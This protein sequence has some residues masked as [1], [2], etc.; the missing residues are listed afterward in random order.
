ML[1]NGLL[2]W[3]PDEVVK[4]SASASMP[5]TFTLGSAIGFPE[6]D[7]IQTV[8]ATAGHAGAKHASSRAQASCL[9]PML[10]SSGECRRGGSNPYTFRYRILSPARLPIPPLLQDSYCRP[11]RS[12]WRRCDKSA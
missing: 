12:R 6:P 11:N 5:V 4:V 9:Q 1:F 10:I 7:W 3:L 8:S 2:V